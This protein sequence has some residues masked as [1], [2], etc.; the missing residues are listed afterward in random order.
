VVVASERL[1]GAPISVQPAGEKRM[2]VACRDGG[3]L[4]MLGE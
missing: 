1:C 3:S 4:W 2:V